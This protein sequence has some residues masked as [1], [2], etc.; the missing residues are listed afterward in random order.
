MKPIVLISPTTEDILRATIRSQEAHLTE[1][2]AKC[3]AATFK[4]ARLEDELLALRAKLEEAR[5]M[6]VWGGHERALSELF[7][8]PLPQNA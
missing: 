5:G 3:H 7:A 8:R 1:L 6:W 4:A 2:E